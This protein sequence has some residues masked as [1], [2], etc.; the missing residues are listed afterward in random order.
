[1]AIRGGKDERA[2]PAHFLVQQA[3]G[4]VDG[5]VGAEGIGADQFGQPVGAMGLGAAHGPHFMEDDG[6]AGA[7]EL[8]GRLAAGKAAAHDMHRIVLHGSNR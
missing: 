3:D 7:G 2:G 5:V 4:I 1:M 6:N 8:P